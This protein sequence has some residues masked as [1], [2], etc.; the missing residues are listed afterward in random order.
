MPPN[1]GRKQFSVTLKNAHPTAYSIISR[2]YCFKTKRLILNPA[3]ASQTAIFSFVILLQ[4]P[5]P[6]NS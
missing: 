2:H 6:V 5:M 4:A 3:L 1:T